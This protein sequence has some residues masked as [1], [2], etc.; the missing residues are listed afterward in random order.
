LPVPKNDK[1]FKFW[2]NFSVVVCS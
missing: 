2:T 1:N